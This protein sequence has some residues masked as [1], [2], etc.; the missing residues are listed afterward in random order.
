[1]MSK[2]HEKWQVSLGRLIDLEKKEKDL[3]RAE[4]L[5]KRLRAENRVLRESQK[6]VFSV[7]DNLKNDPL[8]SDN[9][10]KKYATRL[11]FIRAKKAR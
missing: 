1:M 6:S 3:I 7:L 10:Q 4:A 2:L 8:I 11:A 5:I 9:P